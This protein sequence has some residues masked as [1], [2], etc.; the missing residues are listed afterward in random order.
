MVSLRY[1]LSTVTFKED[2]TQDDRIPSIVANYKRFTF[3]H[4]PVEVIE[5]V[6]LR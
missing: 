1:E 2:E 6:L 5:L 3:K 4:K